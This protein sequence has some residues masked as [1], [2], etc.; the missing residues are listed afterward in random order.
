MGLLD[1]VVN[2]VCDLPCG[3]AE[4]HRDL[5]TVTVFRHTCAGGDTLR[6]L[7]IG[8]EGVDSEEERRLNEERYGFTLTI[9][10]VKQ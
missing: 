8:N 6:Q 9:V 10:T 3:L 4:Q 1:E 2:D 7:A 5:V